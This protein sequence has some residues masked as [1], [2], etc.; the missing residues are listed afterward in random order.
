MSN[1]AESILKMSVIMLYVKPQSKPKRSY[2][3]DAM[4]N[5]KKNSS[6]V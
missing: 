3:V 1:T 5:H 2:H 6:D 4:K